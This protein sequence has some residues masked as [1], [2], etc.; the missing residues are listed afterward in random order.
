MVEPSSQPRFESIVSET[1]GARGTAPGSRIDP[2]TTHTHP[3]DHPHKSKPTGAERATAQCTACCEHA[4]DDATAAP[5]AEIRAAE[6]MR[7]SSQA[8][9]SQHERQRAAQSEVTESSRAHRRA[10]LWTPQIPALSFFSPL[11]CPVVFNAASVTSRL[12]QVRGRH[13]HRERD[14]ERE[15]AGC[16][17]PNGTEARRFARFARRLRACPHASPLL[18][19]LCC[20]VLSFS[21][22]PSRLWPAHRD[23]VGWRACRRSMRMPAQQL[24]RMHRAAHC[25]GARRRTQRSQR[26]TIMGCMSKV[27]PFEPSPHH[28]LLALR[29][30]L[31]SFFV[32]LCICPLLLPSPRPV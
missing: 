29:C 10:G 15:K 22:C 6:S 2:Q 18:R 21:P 14:N 16:N 23:R 30:P 26:R 1:S 13:K 24:R 4:D 9:N 5:T 19:P 20:R 17:E 27:R 25:G 8:R 3:I 11:R 32:S 31:R 12:G 7:H 28:S